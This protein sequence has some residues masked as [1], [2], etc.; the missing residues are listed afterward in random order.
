MSKFLLFFFLSFRPIW[1]RKRVSR[2]VFEREVDGV[3]FTGQCGEEG[4]IWGVT[5][6]GDG[7]AFQG[8]YS[9]G[10]WGQG[11][12]TMNDGEYFIGSFL[13]GTIFGTEYFAVG[14]YVISDGRFVEG[15]LIQGFSL[16][17]LVQFI[18]MMNTIWA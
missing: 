16:L 5:N 9:D 13:G 6:Y 10:S 15:Y 2:Y 7:E 11:I 3:T 8:Y 4:P 17:V 18:T 12:Y 1:A 14:T